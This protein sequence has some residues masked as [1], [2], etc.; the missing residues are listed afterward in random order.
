ML[1]RILVLLALLVLTAH[2]FCAQDLTVQLVNESY[3]PLKH[4]SVAIRYNFRENRA[5][6]KGEVITVRT[7]ATGNATFSNLPLDQG[8]FSVLAGGMCNV[9]ESTPLF[10]LP[11][12]PDAKPSISTVTSAPCSA[13]SSASERPQ[14]T[15]AAAGSGPNSP[16]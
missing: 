7:D 9:A 1:S 4:V 12:D 13:L 14:S 3:V 10:L 5:A 15:A 11:D 6:R 2:T 16:P 8:G